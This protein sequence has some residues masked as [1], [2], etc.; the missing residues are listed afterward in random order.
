ML[1]RALTLPED[2]VEMTPLTG[3]SIAERMEGV[4]EP[5]RLPAAELPPS[6]AGETTPDPTEPTPAFV[7]V[8]SAPHTFLAPGT[9]TCGVISQAERR[10]KS[11]G[12]QRR[13]G[14][15]LT[16]GLQKLGV[17]YESRLYF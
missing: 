16:L 9:S 4:V 15:S 8:V 12:R 7:V 5:S 1:T 14:T 17:G 3:G 2:L 11:A 6:A 13:R 10:R